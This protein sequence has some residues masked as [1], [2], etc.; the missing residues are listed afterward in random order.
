MVK[1]R[2]EMGERGNRPRGRIK[3][4]GVRGGGRER[5]KGGGVKMDTSKL[6]AL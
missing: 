1:S 3:E 2:E 4:E 6:L 5:G